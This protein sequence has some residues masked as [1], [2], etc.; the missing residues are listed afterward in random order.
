MKTPA[1]EE[2]TGRPHRILELKA[3]VMA[4]FMGQPD[5]P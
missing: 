5:C 4:D 3:S 2:Y 1:F